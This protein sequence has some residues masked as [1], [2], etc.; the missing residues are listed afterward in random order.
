M[1]GTNDIGYGKIVLKN[2][3]VYSLE[4]AIL[5]IIITNDWLLTGNFGFKT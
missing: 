2:D 3:L 4:I 5:I 1:S